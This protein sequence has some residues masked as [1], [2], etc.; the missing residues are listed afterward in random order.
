MGAHA[1]G[2][3]CSSHHSGRSTP[4]PELSDEEP[5]CTLRRVQS[6]PTDVIN[7][8][9]DDHEDDEDDRSSQT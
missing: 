5:Q 9:E 7:E 6:Y 3:V 2:C 4:E 1:A 8:T